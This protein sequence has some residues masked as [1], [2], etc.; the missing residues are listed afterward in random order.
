L[1]LFGFVEEHTKWSL[2]LQVGEPL[3]A[4]EQFHFEQLEAV[5]QFHLKLQVLWEVQE[6][7]FW[8]LK[9]SK[10][11][12]ALRREHS[13]LHRHMVRIQNQVE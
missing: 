13:P 7:L 11:L 12:M 8:R 5:E 1:L 3:L 6:E 2:S 9:R 4:V 10:N